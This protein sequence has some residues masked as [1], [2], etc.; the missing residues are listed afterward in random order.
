MLVG[1]EAETQTELGVVLEQGVRPGWAAPGGILGP[2]RDRQVAAVDRGAAGRVGDLEAIPKELRQQ[3]E[4]GGLAAAPA[5]A[6][7]LEQ[8]LQEL[9]AVNIGEVDARAVIHR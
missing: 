4:V 2:G 1:G 5:G 8:R 3:L 7:E 9:N 6:G